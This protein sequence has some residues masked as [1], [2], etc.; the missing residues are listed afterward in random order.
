[1]G[2]GLQAESVLRLVRERHPE[3]QIAY[4][5]FSPSA[6]ALAARQPA[7]FHGYLPYDQPLVVERALELL[8]PR[9][10]IF[11]KLDLWPE[12]AVQARARGVAVGMIAATVSAASGRLR[13]LPRALTRSGYA[14]LAKVG[15]IDSADADRL[16][17]L[18]AP[19]NVITVT[20]DPR[21]DSAWRIAHGVAQ[22]D[23]LL[24]L[25]RGAPAIVAG[26]TWPPD[27]AV[28]LRA[29]LALRAASSNARLILVPHEPT[30]EH[31]ERLEQEALRLGLPAPQRLSRLQEPGPLILV[32]RV[33]ILAAL[34]RAA[35]VAYV[36]GGFGTAGLHSV[37]EPAACGVPTIFGPRWQSSRDADLLLAAGGGAAITDRSRESASRELARLW[38][39]WLENPDERN[40]RGAAALQVVKTGL[41]AAQRNA[42]LVEELVESGAGATETERR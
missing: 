28:L 25:G 31:L 12:L 27:E 40:R 20:G 17:R 3:W 1:V 7:D 4:T 5:Y 14:A 41:G 8:A 29:F 16:V 13:W 26:S 24:A 19:P 2:E 10:L 22:D 37:L 33:G 23:P 15:A 32:D 18:G 39:E 34:Y 36:G 30:P 11:T 9:A 35:A 6:E 21:F 38:T 42:A